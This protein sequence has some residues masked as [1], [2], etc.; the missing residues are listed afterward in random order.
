MRKL[1][2]LLLQNIGSYLC[3]L[4]KLKC[5]KLCQN[6]EQKLNEIIKNL[7]TQYISQP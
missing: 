4:N 2:Y 3:C 6:D 5:Y 1:L 7:I